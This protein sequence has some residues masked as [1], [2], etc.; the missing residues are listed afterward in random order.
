MAGPCTAV[1]YAMQARLI[2]VAEA[3]GDVK[4]KFFWES[5]CSIVVKVFF[6]FSRRFLIENLLGNQSRLKHKCGR[7]QLMASH[8][9]SRRKKLQERVVSMM[10]KHYR[11]SVDKNV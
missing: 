11:K 8:R 1:A 9:V 10:N 6:V 4:S 7:M 3:V 2:V 5:I